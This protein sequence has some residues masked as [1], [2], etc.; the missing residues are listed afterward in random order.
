MFIDT[1]LIKHFQLKQGKQ[2]NIFCITF[3][4]TLEISY[5]FTILFDEMYAN[6]FW[7]ILSPLT[8]LRLKIFDINYHFFKG[9]K[10]LKIVW[11]FFPKSLRRA[12]PYCIISGQEGRIRWNMAVVFVLMFHSKYFINS[13]LNSSVGVKSLI[14][15]FNF[16]A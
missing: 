3:T 4:L 1:P 12:S 10:I 6:V 5:L 15:L 13:M 9:L 16:F 11:R 7:Y 8:R 2:L 14:K